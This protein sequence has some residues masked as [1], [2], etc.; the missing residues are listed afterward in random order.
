[1]FY[2]CFHDD[3]LGLDDDLHKMTLYYL[4]GNWD[5]G[6]CT[7]RFPKVESCVTCTQIRPG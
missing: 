7:A 2:F 3:G 5:F 4:H 1:M 6:I